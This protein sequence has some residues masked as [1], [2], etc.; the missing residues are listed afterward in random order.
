MTV[1]D[2]TFEEYYSNQDLQEL[3]AVV[4]VLKQATQVQ[5]LHPVAISPDDIDMVLMAQYHWHKK[6]GK[7][8]PTNV[9]VNSEQEGK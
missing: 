9:Q 4:E 2:M 6:K 5:V 7:K 1:V 3:H 8:L